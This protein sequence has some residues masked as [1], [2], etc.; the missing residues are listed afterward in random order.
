MY[1]FMQVIRYT[2]IRHAHQESTYMN[3]IAVL[4]IVAVTDYFHTFIYKN[5]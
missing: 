5:V 2:S 3:F 1:N 4:Q